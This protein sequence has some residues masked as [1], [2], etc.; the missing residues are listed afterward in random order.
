MIRAQF[1]KKSRFRKMKE[2]NEIA[3]EEKV[4]AKKQL[5]ATGND[6][7]KGYC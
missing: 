2:T 7:Y 3:T 1:R 6:S 4:E 5:N